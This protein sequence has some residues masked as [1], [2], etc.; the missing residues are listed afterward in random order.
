MH[1]KLDVPTNV[2]LDAS[3]TGVGAVLQQRINLISMMPY[4]LFEESQAE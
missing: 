1:P 2:V 3:N 4:L